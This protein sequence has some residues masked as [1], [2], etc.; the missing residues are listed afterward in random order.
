MVLMQKNF[1]VFEKSDSRIINVCWS[2]HHKKPHPLRIKLICHYAYPL[3]SQIPINQ[4]SCQSATIKIMQ[5]YTIN[6]YND[7]LTFVP[8]LELRV[9]SIPVWFGKQSDVC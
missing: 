3:I 8:E 6:I 7:D 4:P 2:V 5:Y 1:F 9:F